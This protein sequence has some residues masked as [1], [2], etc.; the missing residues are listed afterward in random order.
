M[1]NISSLHP[2][3]SIPMAPDTTQTLL[4]A[5]SSGQAADW[6]GG[7][8]QVVRVTAI[9]TAGVAITAHVN[10]ASTKAL[11]P[12]S[13]HSTL[14]SSANVP[15]VGQGTFQVAGGSTGFSVAALSSGYV[16]LEQWHL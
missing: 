8:P 9:S 4:I 10:L 6:A 13:G 7:T 15:I 11:A 16:I 3:E 5:G 12:S 2:T 14:A 1:R